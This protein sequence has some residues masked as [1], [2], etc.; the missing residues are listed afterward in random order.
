MKKWMKWLLISGALCCFAGA[1]AVAAGAAMGGGHHLGEALRRG[2]RWDH[3]I[4]P[5][6]APSSELSRDFAENSSSFS[7]QPLPGTEEL[8]LTSSYSYEG[9]RHLKLELFG[10]HVAIRQQEDLTGGC[11]RIGR[12]SGDGVSYRIEQKG[13]ELK[14]QLP[15]HHVHNG[16]EIMESL[17]IDIPAGYEFDEIEI[18]NA[19]GSLEADQIMARILDMEDTGGETL[20]AGGSVQQLELECKAGNSVCQAAVSGSLSVEC[21]GGE[22]L[23]LLAGEPEQYDYKLECSLGSI[24]LG[25]R[26]YSGPHMEEHLDHH[27]GRK[28]EVE[29]KAGTVT[30]EFQEPMI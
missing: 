9:V 18:E 14:V 28:A 25:G 2:D 22:A 30:V 1:G 4:V 29:C 12:G 17:L 27:A 6:T 15:K 10:N 21:D 23:V 26:E 5:E 20:I 7:G 19:G 13:N 11:I 8:P 24:L 16:G 3:V